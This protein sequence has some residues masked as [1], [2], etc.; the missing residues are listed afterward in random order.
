[1]IWATSCVGQWV[2]NICVVLFIDVLWVNFFLFVPRFQFLIVLVGVL[3]F[4][5]GFWVIQGLF[6][7][8]VVSGL[9]AVT[10]PVVSGEPN[11]VYN[12]GLLERFAKNCSAHERP[13]G[14]RMCLEGGFFLV[15]PHR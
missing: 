11:C 9:A 6:L 14:C 5:L 4:L 8:L 3:L 1:M 2:N 10:G 15:H 7:W 13:P 12:L